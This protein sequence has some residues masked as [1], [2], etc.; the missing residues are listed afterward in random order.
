M[1]KSAVR[2]TRTMQTERVQGYHE[3]GSWGGQEYAYAGFKYAGLIPYRAS[4][5]TAYLDTNN[6]KVNPKTM[7]ATPFNP[8]GFGL[9]IETGCDGILSDR[10]Y[11][12]VLK[13]VLFPILPEGFFK[14]QR[15]GSLSGRSSAEII[16]GVAT[17][18]AWRNMYPA[19]KQM[20]NEFFPLF[21]IHA[22]AEH[23]CGMHVNISRGLLGKTE[24]AQTETA[25]KLLYFVNHNYNFCC[26]LFNRKGD[27]Y[28][29]SQM[30][31]GSPSEMWAEI[32]RRFDGLKG[33]N[34]HGLCF[35]LS[36]WDAGRLEIRLVGGQEKY[37]TFRNTMETI[38][39]LLPRLIK[40]QRKDLDNL[41]K[42]FTGCNKYVYDRL[43][44]RCRDYI[45]GEDLARVIE[46][47]TDEEYF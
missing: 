21:D 37:G 34:N 28:Y 33:E 11:A 41:G 45:Q 1:R 6:N 44:T 25:K 31:S 4:D 3:G 19:L 18:E 38:F 36:H 7:E 35:N 42:V 9:E 17:K 5:R 20:F 10:A 47:L 12:T 22:D 24:E 13:N 30:F 40:L 14:L 15:D 26:K 8:L 32:D 23:G 2:E 16:S 43:S 29:C 46:T 27:T 39:F